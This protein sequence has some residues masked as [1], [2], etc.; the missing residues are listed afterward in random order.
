MTEPIRIA[1]I[2]VFCFRVPVNMPIKVTFGTFR[3]WPF[4]LV[5][6]TDAQGHHGQGEVWANWPAVGAEH[7]A[8]L[9]V[10]I[11][12]RLVGQTFDGPVDFLRPPDE[13]AGSAVAADARGG[14][15]AQV[16]AGLD[17]AMWD[18]AARRAGR[19]LHRL[20]SERDPATVP[21]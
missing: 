4:V 21:V 13:V 12:E 19:P 18:L 3:D 1:S 10:D 16:V 9:V 5:C 2:E 7:R 20:L 8:R 17:I 15:I 6:V 11:G 14:P